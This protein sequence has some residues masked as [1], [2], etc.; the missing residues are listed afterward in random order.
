MGGPAWSALIADIVPP[1]ERG[2]VLGLMGTVAGLIS[3]PGGIV[4]GMIYDSN[5]SLLLLSGS[6]LEAMSI[7]IILLFIRDVQEKKE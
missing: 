4:G 6:I 2:K 3:L 1:A 5:P 7:P